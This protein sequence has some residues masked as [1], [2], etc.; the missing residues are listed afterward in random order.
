MD[1][2]VFPE[3]RFS[4]REGNKYTNIF[5]VIYS[6]LYY[7]TYRKT[8][9]NICSRSRCNLTSRSNFNTK[10]LEGCSHRKHSKPCDSVVHLSF[11]LTLNQLDTLKLSNSYRFISFCP[12]L[13]SLLLIFIRVGQLF[14]MIKEIVFN[15]IILFPLWLINIR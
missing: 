5:W 13:F 6:L 14:I 2:S 3:S 8:R 4:V 12:Y 9:G 15:C 7:N 1:F 11:F 10:P